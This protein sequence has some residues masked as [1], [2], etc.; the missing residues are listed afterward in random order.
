VAG[1]SVISATLAGGVLGAPGGSFVLAEWTDAGESSRDAPIA[2]LH[3]H[4]DEDEAWY[5][6]E[7]MLGFRVGDDEIVAEPGVAVVAP[8]GT[9]HT[10]W[11]ACDGT[12]RYLL[13]M[14]LKTSRLIAAIH[15]AT[16]RDLPTMQALF[17]A[18]GS[19]LLG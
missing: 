9:P 14:G 2:P 8:R 17:R 4:L 12:A 6:L 1:S 5:V 10:Y 13:V 18:H 16:S 15:A 11:N 7:G 19:E 3:V